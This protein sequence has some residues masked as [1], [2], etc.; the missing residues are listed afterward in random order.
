MITSPNGA[1]GTPALF[2]PDGEL[3][4]PTERARGPWSPGALHGGPVAALIARSIERHVGEDHL[5]VVRIT[6]EFLRPVPMT[7]LEVRT[8]MVKSGRRVQLVDVVVK[9]DGEDVARARALRIR[10]DPGVGQPVPSV[11]EGDAPSPPET[12]VHSPVEADGYRAFHNEGMELRFVNGEFDRPGPATVW[13][14]LR[15]PVVAGEAPTPLQRAVAAADFGNGVSAELDFRSSVFINP[16]LTVSVQRLPVGEWVCLDARTRFGASGI[17]V[18]ESALWDEQGRF[19][20]AV[21][22]LLVEVGQ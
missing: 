11:P 13:F 6:V 7:P 3:V 10:T 2:V 19:G 22:N 17:G 1:V 14:R 16:D 12:G 5:Q 8:S 9:A 15:C 4:L 18:A 21:Q 20:H